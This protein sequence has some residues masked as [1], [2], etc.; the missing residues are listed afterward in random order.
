M[1]KILILMIYKR[2]F[3]SLSLSIEQ[4]LFVKMQDYFC[5]FLSHHLILPSPSS[6]SFPV[7][8]IPVWF[9]DFLIS[10][11]LFIA[12]FHILFLHVLTWYITVLSC[13]T[14]ITH[15]YIFL[16]FP[17]RNKYEGYITFDE[18]PNQIKNGFYQQK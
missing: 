14:P 2:F 13:S 16:I 11:C 15:C 10:T 18:N 1:L 3:G 7:I 6:A 9:K 17:V 8:I 4:H 5:Y 12:E